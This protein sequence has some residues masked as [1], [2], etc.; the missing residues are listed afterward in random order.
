LSSPFLPLSPVY[1]LFL[2]L[3]STFLPLLPRIFAV[4]TPIFCCY[5]PHF[6]RPL[7]IAARGDPPS[8]LPSLRHLIKFSLYSSLLLYNVE[9]LSRICL[10]MSVCLS[11]CLYQC[12]FLCVFVCRRRFH[13]FRRPVRRQ[14]SS[15]PRARQIQQFP[16]PNLRYVKP[17]FTAAD[18]PSFAIEY[19]LLTGGRKL[20]NWKMTDEVA[21][22]GG[23]CK[24]TQRLVT[25]ADVAQC[26]HLGATGMGQTSE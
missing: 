11:I 21:G 8:P 15:V 7:L 9:V 20:W 5:R 13:I 24:T 6:C 18:L 17:S 12:L 23:Q 16:C 10:R 26:N 3:S 22:R 1:H 19:Q 4:T 2:P 25:N 14:S